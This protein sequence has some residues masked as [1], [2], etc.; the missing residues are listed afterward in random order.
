MSSEWVLLTPQGKPDQIVYVNLSRASSIWSFEGGSEIWFRADAGEEG[1]A[2][3]KETPEEI[4][5]SNHSLT[6]APRPRG[7]AM[8]DEA[9]IL[10]RSN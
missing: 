6:Q 8:R 2:R 9:T 5:A 10:L 3:V 1:Y 7:S 4:I